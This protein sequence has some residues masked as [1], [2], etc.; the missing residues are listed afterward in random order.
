MVEHKRPEEKRSNKKLNF[1]QHKKTILGGGLVV[2]VAIAGIITGIILSDSE[3]K[4]GGGTVTMGFGDYPGTFDPILSW[5][6]WEV[7]GV[8]IVGQ[9][10]EGLFDY[11]VSSEGSSIINNLA[12]SYEWSND[13]LNL[14]CTLREDVRFHDN[15]RFN[16]QAVKWNFDRFYYLFTFFGGSYSWKLPN[17]NWII[18]KTEVISEYQVRFVLNEPFAPFLS[19]LASRFTYILSPTSTV[20][21]DF[22]GNNPND[23]Y[24]TGPFQ[25]HSHEE[26]MIVSLSA[27][28]NYWGGWPDIDEIIFRTYSNSS[29]WWEAIKSKDSSINRVSLSDE[30]VEELNNITGIS[31]KEIVRTS[32]NLLI[33]N[34]E[35]INVTMRKA[36]SYAINYTHYLEEVRANNETRT[37]SPIPKPVLYSNWEDFNV[38]YCNIS[39]ARKTLKDA[40]W[41]GTA[42]LTANDDISPDNEWE[43]IANSSFPIAT[44]NYTYIPWIGYMATLAQPL[45]EYLQQIGIKV[46]LKNVTY[47]Q[48]IGQL[49][50]RYGWPKRLNRFELFALGWN[51]DYNEPHIV[52]YPMFSNGGIE[53]IA[54][55]NDSLIQQWMEE[56]I[57]ET[58]DTLRE[59]LYDDIQKRL[60][61]ELYPMAWLYQDKSYIVYLS[62]MNGLQLNNPFKFSLK[63]VELH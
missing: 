1:S 21:D 3:L 11:A 15:T 40:G 30:D 58:N 56:A 33:M 23:V 51:P 44:Y 53:N 57:L 18:N 4:R 38:P 31:V 34:N 32:N 41:N 39:L 26:N 20:A 43:T 48:M 13:D 16:A 49:Y 10:A 5:Y 7:E 17:G 35:R 14:T 9:M 37:R 19:L 42:G 22:I 59:Q 27:N 45:T 61:E 25:Y 24:G 29:V 2:A 47:G 62:K 12:T 63:N 46:E 52:I 8:M 6:N 36:I 55:V 50:G 60:I 28:E 54:Q